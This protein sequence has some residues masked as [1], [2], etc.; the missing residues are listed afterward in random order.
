MEYSYAC[1]EVRPGLGPDPFSTPALTEAITSADGKL[2]SGES[3]GW[4]ERR[5]SPW[6]VTLGSWP[7]HILHIADAQYRL[8][9]QV[10]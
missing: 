6:A 5:E 9:A 7:L 10:F 4:P 1:L 3:Q 2:P 8:T